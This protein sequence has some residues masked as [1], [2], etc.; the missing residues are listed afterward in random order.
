[1]MEVTG[2]ILQVCAVVVGAIGTVVG[3]SASPS[4]RA[5]IVIA[6]IVAA[7]LLFGIGAA[8]AA[9]DEIQRNVR[10]SADANERIAQAVE[11]S[12]VVGVPP[13]VPK[14]QRSL[15]DSI[16]ARS[17]RPPTSTNK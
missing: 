15:I 6:S 16:E 1:M 9:L 10:R 3:L 12:P 17:K 2:R 14:V 4:S 11:Y 13:V 7:F 5:L 8:L